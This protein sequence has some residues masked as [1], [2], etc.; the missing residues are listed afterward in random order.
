MTS[1]ERILAAFR[2]EERDRV[3]WAPEL[4][5]QVVAR[6]LERAGEEPPSDCP[7]PAAWKYGVANELIGADALW[8]DAAFSPAWR[9]PAPAQRPLP[10][11]GE[12]SSAKP[13]MGNVHE[14]G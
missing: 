12:L 10:I 2:N 7:D 13:R 6:E 14:K 8:S 9:L 1:R 11:V 4:N 5:D 3:G